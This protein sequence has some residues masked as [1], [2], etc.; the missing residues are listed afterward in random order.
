MGGAENFVNFAIKTVISP[1]Q[2]TR[3]LGAEI[4]FSKISFSCQESVGKNAMRFYANFAL[5]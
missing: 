5:C 4:S 2:Y 1:H 3:L